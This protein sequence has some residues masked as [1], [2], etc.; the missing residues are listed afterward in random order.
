MPEVTP[1]LAARVHAQLLRRGIEV[2][3]GAKISSVEGGQVVL[4][5]GTSFA[6]DTIVVAAGSVPN[7]LLERTDLPL[8]ARGPRALRDHAAGRATAPTCSP[9]ATAPRC[10][11]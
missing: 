2:R 1:A 3:V 10:P 5:G 6:T 8:D 9:P 4:A 7:P 11:T